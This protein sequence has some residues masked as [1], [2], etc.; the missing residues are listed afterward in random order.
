[1][2]NLG[3][4][5]SI[6]VEQLLHHPKVEGPSLATASGTGKAEKAEKYGKPWPEVVEHLLHHPK[7]K[8]SCPTATWH[9]RTERHLYIYLGRD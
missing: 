9:Q 8:G 3:K 4:R 2:V 1:M 5:N 7:V 6:L